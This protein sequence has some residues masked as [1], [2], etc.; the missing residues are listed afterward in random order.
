MTSPE[1]RP[2]DVLSLM[3][4]IAGTR[5][6]PYEIESALGAGG[7]GDLRPA[8]QRTRSLFSLDIFNVLNVDTITGL[9]PLYIQTGLTPTA[10][11]VPRLLKVSAT[12]DF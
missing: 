10:I 8:S 7:M 12:V 9:N 11:V 1:T 3:T 4:L 2:D 6:G 5:L